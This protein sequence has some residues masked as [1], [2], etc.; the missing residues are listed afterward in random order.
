MQPEVDKEHLQ[1]VGCN[2]N[3]TYNKAIKRQRR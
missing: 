3:I 2:F 1:M